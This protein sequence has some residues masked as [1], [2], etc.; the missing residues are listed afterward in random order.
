MSTPTKNVAY[1]FPI[2]LSRGGLFIANP[3]IA[4]GDFKVSTDNGAFTNLTT[5]PVVTPAGSIDVLVSLSAAEMN[6]D[7]ISVHALDQTDP[8]EW[9]EVK[10]LIEIDENL[11]EIYR[12]RGLDASNPKTITEIID[13]F[14]YN[15]DSTDINKEVRKDGIVTTVTRT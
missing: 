8:T 12:D 9:D 13:G 3:T 5:L 15:E 2:S 1:D 6:G 14:S 4:S 7:T 10:A 11:T